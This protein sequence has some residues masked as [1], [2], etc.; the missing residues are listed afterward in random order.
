[1][2]SV[3]TCGDLLQWYQSDRSSSWKTSKL[4]EVMVIKFFILFFIDE[5][6][7]NDVIILIMNEIIGDS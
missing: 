3:V 7:D 2:C 5:I 6:I 1:M 4:S